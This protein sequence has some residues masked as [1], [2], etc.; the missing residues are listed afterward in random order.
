MLE[1]SANVLYLFDFDGTLFGRNDWVSLKVNNRSVKT[2]GPYLNP[3]DIGIRW[4]VLTGR[5]RIDRF[6]VWRHCHMNG[7]HPTQI[8]MY[9]T[10]FF[11]KPLHPTEAINDYKIDVMKRIINGTLEL[12][13]QTCQI[14][15]IYYMDN[16]IPVVSYINSKRESFPFQAMTVI[17]F[18]KQDFNY[19]L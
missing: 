15:K 5:P 12:K 4:S 10:V 11:P 18:N 3:G 1:K 19:L 14:D 8:L 13:K 2:D 17:D 9:K 16:D 6:F 7:L